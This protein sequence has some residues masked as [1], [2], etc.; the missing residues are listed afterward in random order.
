MKKE[1][2]HSKRKS[3]ALGLG[4][5]LGITMGI[6]VLIILVMLNLF[7]VVYTGNEMKNST[8]KEI[9]LINSSNIL[10]IDSIIE[11]CTSIT[12]TIISTMN[13]MTDENDTIS[14]DEDF[15]STVN[16]SKI[17]KSRYIAEQEILNSLWAAFNSNDNLVNAC[18]LLEPFAFSDSFDDYCMVASRGDLSSKKLTGFS[19]NDYKEKAYYTYVKSNKTIYFSDAYIDQVTGDSVFSLS[20]PILQ[21]GEFKGL[22]LLDINNNIF[23]IINTKSESFPSLSTNIINQNQKI[24]YSTQSE[25][26]GKPL[27]ELLTAQTYEKINGKFEANQKFSITTSDKNGSF[28]RYYTP[29]N[30]GG[31]TWWME[32]SVLSKEYNAAKINLS[33]I[34]S[35]MSLI[36]AFIIIT[37]MIIMLKKSLKPLKEIEN[38][39][40]EM[41]KGSLNVNIKYSSQDEIGSLADSMRK[42]MI[43]IK[44]I[45]ANLAYS[46]EELS[47]GNFAFQNNREEIYVGDYLPLQESIKNI[48]HKLSSTMSD[49]KHA[50]FEVNSGAEQVSSAAQALSQGATEQASSIEEL[51]ATME[52]IS[53]KIKVN[54][55]K[56]NEA[57]ELAQNAGNEVVISNEKMHQMTLAMQDITNKSNEINKIIKTIDDI[58][59]QTNILALNAAVEAARAGAAGKGFA[60]VADEVRNLAQKSAEAA[61]NTTVLIQASI[62]AVSNG[63]KLTEETAKALNAVAENVVRVTSLINEISCASNEQANGVAQI[64]LGIEQISTVVQTNSATAEESAAASEELSGQSGMLNGLVSQFSLKEDSL[65]SNL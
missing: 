48:S 54:A 31:T 32:S 57:S 22:I 12:D 9:N 4:V 59:F 37:A 41:T 52:D 62:T 51:S 55:D 23:S 39:A 16:N 29:L 30:V 64:S 21:N 50:S 35:V 53:D 1:A 33:L 2:L 3:K 40:C 47:D 15:I 56:A 24:L 45:I 46:L 7:V 60:V 42:M 65:S 25:I 34:L 17:S 14:E 11:V 20:F 8:N 27:N 43:Q 18:L 38:A 28:V 13:D 19:Y 36:S 49:I 61:K 63:G 6:T 5:K 10:K 44:E 58:A 26:T